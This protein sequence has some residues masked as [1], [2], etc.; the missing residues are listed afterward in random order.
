MDNPCATPEP[1]STRQ[2]VLGVFIVGQLFFLISTNLIG[3]LKDNRAEMGSQARQVVE[4]V[5]PGWPEE[6]GHLWHLMEHL[7]RLDKSW[8][9]LTGQFQ[10]WTLFAPTIGR[11]CVF[12]AVEFRWEEEPSSAPALAR[13]L[14]LLAARHGYEAACLGALIHSAEKMP[15]VS[16]LALSENEPPNPEHY[17]RIGNFRMR[18]YETNIV[19][20][21]R[22]YEEDGEK[23]EKTNQRWSDRIHAHVADYADI[24][25]GYLHWSLDQAAARQSNREPPRQVILVLR[26]YHIND[27]EDAPPFWTGPHTVAIARW[28]PG[29]TWDASHQALEWYDPVSKSLKGLRK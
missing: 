20:T 8:A 4:A 21:L 2:V 1:P 17:F 12:P 28:Q 23:P 25:L 6:K 3:F 26:R 13:P 24:I 14:A 10:P 5:A 29:V 7:A 16:E 15:L 22:P 27:Y 18:R 9:Q 19:I 11:E